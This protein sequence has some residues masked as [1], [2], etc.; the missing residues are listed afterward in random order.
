MK[1]LLAIFEL[2]KNEQ[3]VVLIVMFVLLA[4]AFVGYERRIHHPS[5]QR[6]LATEPKPSPTPAESEND[7]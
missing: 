1:R 4:L 3:R 7:H 5:V 2:T 6:A